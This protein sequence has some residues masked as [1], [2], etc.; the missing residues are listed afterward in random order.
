MKI[1]QVNCSSLVCYNL[2][3]QVYCHSHIVI[4]KFIFN[5]V[6]NKLYVPFIHIRLFVWLQIDKDVYI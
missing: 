4:E 1:N 5:Y 3:N 2:R 6:D